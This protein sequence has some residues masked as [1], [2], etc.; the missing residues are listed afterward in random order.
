M[1]AG[2]S[3]QNDVLRIVHLSDPQ[4]GKYHRFANQGGTYDDI[5]NYLKL[6]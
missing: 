5:L 4:Y 3:K 1:S 6:K 2:P